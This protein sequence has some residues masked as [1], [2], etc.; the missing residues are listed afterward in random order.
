M[1]A[2]ANANGR[3]L[4]QVILQ[5]DKTYTQNEVTKIVNDW[6]KKEVKQ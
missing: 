3:N 2:E 6:K 1:N 4:L 5:D